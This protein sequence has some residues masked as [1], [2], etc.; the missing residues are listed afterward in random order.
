MV[1]ALFGA[2]SGLAGAAAS[3]SS[4]D[5]V[6]VRT[7]Y[8]GTTAEQLIRVVVQ[9]EAPDTALSDVQI[10]TDSTQQTLVE[11][12]SYTTEVAPGNQKVSVNPKPSGDFEI[13]ELT[14]GERVTISFAVV[15]ERLDEA[16]LD[17]ATVHVDYV[18][19]GQ[20]LTVDR[21]ATAN[22]SANPWLQLQNAQ[23]QNNELAGQV[24]QQRVTFFAGL[25]V[26]LVG[27]ATAV[28]AEFRRRRHIE[29]F[30]DDLR[31]QLSDAYTELA[32]TEQPVIERVATR[33][34][35]ELNDGEPGLET[36]ADRS[37]RASPVSDTGSGG[38]APT[39]GPVSDSQSDDNSPNTDADSDDDDDDDFD[40]SY[41]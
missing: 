4:A 14:P 15:P 36:G 10:R 38:E 8:N 6:S 27:I 5:A 21:V 33:L 3:Q 25:A 31:S 37:H 35:V 19:R 16:R 13:K 26:G 22:L 23:E 34:G 11:P 7:S 12:S 28:G 40:P 2:A 39:P 1:V 29:A 20:R 30:E 17:A 18:K 32:A 9:I 41:L 24:G